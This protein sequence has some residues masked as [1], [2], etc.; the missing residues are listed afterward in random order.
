MLRNELNY[1]KIRTVIKT[2]HFRLRNSK[3]CTELQIPRNKI[4]RRALNGRSVSN[5][6]QISNCQK[7]RKMGLLW[8][9]VSG[10][11]MKI[12][13]SQAKV[14]CK[15]SKMDCIFTPGVKSMP[16]ACCC[17]KRGKRGGVKSVYII[18]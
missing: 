9:L 12:A 7:A 11:Y 17:R 8:P 18:L 3:K 15:N 5:L 4:I 2:R 6:R 14:L 16:S 13:L 1:A 10:L